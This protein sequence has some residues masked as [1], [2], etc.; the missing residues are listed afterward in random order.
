[1][2][3]NP[4]WLASKQVTFVCQVT[5]N[6][7]FSLPGYAI[8]VMQVVVAGA[9]YRIVVWSWCTFCILALPQQL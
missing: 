2:I 7:F 4:N 3:A 6:D 1:M 8:V 5:L 9:L